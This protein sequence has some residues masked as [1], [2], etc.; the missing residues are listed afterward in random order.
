MTALLGVRNTKH[1]SSQSVFKTSN[2]AIRPKH[3]VKQIG[4]LV[5]HHN[6]KRRKEKILFLKFPQQVG[7]KGIHYYTVSVLYQ[8]TSEYGIK[9]YKNMNMSLPGYM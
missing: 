4:T 1:D 8:N 3:Q 9:Y 5:F 7:G 2:E 6:V